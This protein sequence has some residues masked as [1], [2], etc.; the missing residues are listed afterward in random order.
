MDK[1][2]FSYVH[3]N[4]MSVIDYVPTEWRRVIYKFLSTDLF[5][6]RYF[7]E[8]F[9]ADSWVMFILSHKLQGRVFFI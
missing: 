3:R 1:L 5:A 9:Y 7:A 6:E 8:L 4:T 2:D